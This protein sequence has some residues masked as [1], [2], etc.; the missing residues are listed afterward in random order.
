MIFNFKIKALFFT[1]ATC[2]NG[3]LSGLK[4]TVDPKS[5]HKFFFLFFLLYLYD[6]HDVNYFSKWKINTEF[7][8]LKKN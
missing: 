3:R 2:E 7:L 6:K 8:N 5:S 4:L 1:S